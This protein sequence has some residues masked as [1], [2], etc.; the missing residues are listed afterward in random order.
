MTKDK[1][2][3]QAWLAYRDDCVAAGLR[4][5]RLGSEYQAGFDA[6]WDGALKS[7]DD[8]DTDPAPQLTREALTKMTPAEIAKLEWAEVVRVLRGGESEG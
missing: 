1:Q 6:G 4:P 5:S 7:L 2:R 8:I 3:K